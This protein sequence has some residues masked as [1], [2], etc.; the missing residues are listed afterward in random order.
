MRYRF[1]HLSLLL[2]MVLLGSVVTTSALAKS[3]K[4]QQRT[5]VV[6]RRDTLSYEDSRRYAYFFLEASRQQNAGNFSGAFDLINHCLDINPNAAEAYYM[7]SKYYTTLH[8]DTLGLRDLETA[9]RLQPSNSTYQESVAQLYIGIG[10]YDKAID[11]YER[12]YATHR[13]RDDVLE[14]LVQLYRQ[15]RDYKHMLD[16]INRLEQVDGGSDQ[17]T[18]MRVNAYEMM[19]DTK[20]A[21][22]TLKG[23]ADSHPNDLNF[24]IMLGNWLMQHKRQKE[25]Y[26]LYEKVMRLEPDNAYAQGAMYDYYRA[27]SQDTLASGMMQRILLGRNTPAATRIQFLRQAIQDNEQEG[28]DST[29]I[30]GL[31]DKIQQVVPT[32]TMVA[33]LKVAYYSLKKLPKDTI[34]SA[35]VQLLALQPDNAAARMQLIQNNWGKDNWKEIARLSEPGM[36]YNPDEMVFYFFNGLSRYYLKDDD[37]ALDVLKRGAAE[38]NDQ[39]SPDIVADLYSVMG[40]IY[41]NKGLNQEAY[42]AYDSCLIYKP[43]NIVTLNNYAYFLSVDGKQLPKAEEMSAKAV[44]AEPKNA[45]YL[46]TYAWILYK[47]QRFAEAKVYIDMALKNSSD[48]TS[49]GTLYEHAG[50]IYSELHDYK[51]AVAYYKQ[52]QQRGGDVKALNRKIILYQKRIQKSK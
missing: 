40:E 48:S 39:S 45:T 7:R 13:D 17:I 43:D 16:A 1:L 8:L 28:G 3:R 18:M 32:D 24:T 44:K 5:T 26:S 33:Q 11:A 29:K 34:D 12:L 10:N 15:Q 41:H 30:I 37:G 20:N 4:K 23:L 42:A 52:A 19:G 31:I 2:T 47:Q 21:Y 49:D 35:L 51:A 38:I 6:G 22:A 25:A 9:A 36:M 14:V 27:T 46:D 50:D